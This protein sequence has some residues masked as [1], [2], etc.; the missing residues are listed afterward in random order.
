MIN[1]NIYVLISLT[2]VLLGGGIILSFIVNFWYAFP[3]LLIGL[4][5]L[6]VYIFFGSVN[7]AAKH[8]QDGDFDAADKKLNLTLKP[9]WLYV[10]QR[11]FYYIMKGSIAMNNKDMKT[12]ESLFDHALQMDL[13][14]DNEK[15]MVLLQLANINASKNK[16]RAAKNYYRDIKKLKVTEAQIKEQVVQFEKALANS[17]QI[18]AARSMGKQGMQMMQAGG[19]S[20]RRRPKM[21]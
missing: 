1:I 5:L 19:K 11:A 10:T 8:I 2:V 12:A 21:R 13:P 4:I 16:W 9:D 6:A 14:S 20:K 15:A 18:K 3:L 7:S 17:G